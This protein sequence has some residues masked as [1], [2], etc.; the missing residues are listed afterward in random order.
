MA[1]R[2]PLRM[3]NWGRGDIFAATALEEKSW[4]AAGWIPKP[5]MPPVYTPYPMFLKGDNLPNL[6][7]ENAE[8]AAAASAKGYVVPS[9]AELEE[10]EEDFA[11]QFAPDIEDYYEPQVYPKYIYHILLLSRKPP[12]DGP[13]SSS[14]RRAR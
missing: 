7:V 4:I 14:V 3:T 5:D 13:C 1:D 10:A 12:A 8:Q 9:D 11:A 6:V 2:Y